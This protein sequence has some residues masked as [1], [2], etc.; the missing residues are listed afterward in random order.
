MN[1]EFASAVLDFGIAKCSGRIPCGGGAVG[2]WM[3]LERL[4]TAKTYDGFSLFVGFLGV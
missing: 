4:L 2:F 1:G 3:P